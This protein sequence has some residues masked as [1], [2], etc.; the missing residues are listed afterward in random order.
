VSSHGC[1][2]HTG[3]SSV[4]PPLIKDIGQVGLGPTLTASFYLYHFFK[5]LISKYGLF[6][7][8]MEFGTMTYEFGGVTVRLMTH[9]FPSSVNRSFQILYIVQM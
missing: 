3:Q 2:A 8:V 4:S 5:D 7:E 1:P 6:F 9:S